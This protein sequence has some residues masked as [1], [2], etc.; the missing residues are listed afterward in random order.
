MLNNPAWSAYYLWKNGEPVAE[1]AA[2]FPKTMHALRNAPLAHVPNRSPSILFSLLTARRA[3]PAAQRPREHAPHLPPAGGRAW[4][5][6]VPRRQRDARLGRGQGLGFRRLDRAR[7]LERKRPDA[8]HTA[9]RRLAPGVDRRESA[10]SSY[11]CSR[12]SMHTAARSR[13]GRS[14]MR[15]AAHGIRWRSWRCSARG[16]HSARKTSAPPSDACRAEADDARRLAC[17][18]RAAGRA[19]GAEPAA[20]PPPRPRCDCGCADACGDRGSETGGQFRPRAAA[21]LRRRPEAGRGHARRGRTPGDDRR[22]R[23]AHGRPHDLHARQRRRCG[24]RSGRTRS[25]ASSRATRS[26]SSRARSARSSCPG[27]PRNRR[28]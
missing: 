7:G 6:P 2:R 11:R 13:T 8:G 14:D 21:G 12:P 28:G 15:L 24:G 27:P 16:P 9:V 10:S 22:A 20:A 25:S 23:E 4:K 26:A 5:V 19:T 17:Y 18:D 1:N 3:H